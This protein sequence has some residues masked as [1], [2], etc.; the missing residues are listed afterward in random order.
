MKKITISDLDGFTDI[1]ECEKMLGA[2]MKKLISI[3]L[4]IYVNLFAIFAQDSLAIDKDCAE[5]KKIH[6]RSKY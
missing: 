3:F 5:L 4:I 2:V 1:C 6:A